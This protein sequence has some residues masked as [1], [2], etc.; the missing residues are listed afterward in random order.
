LLQLGLVLLIGVLLS[1]LASRLRVPDILLFVLVGFGLAQFPFE[2]NPVIGFTPY[3][4][5]TVSLFA[6]ALIVFEGSANFR[7]GE[8]DH[9]SAATLKLILWSIVLHMS[10][11]TAAAVMLGFPVG[12]AAVFAGILLGT[13]AP[14]VIPLLGK[15][16][17]EMF[18]LLKLESLLNTPVNV[19][20]PFLLLDLV[21]ATGGHD[22]FTVA[23]AQL[24]PFLLKLFVGIG[25]GVLAGIILFKVFKRVYEKVH[26]P[27]SLLISA[28]VSFSIAEKLGGSGVLAVTAQGMLFGNMYLAG[29]LRGRLMEVQ[30]VFSRSLYILL[31]MLFGSIL[32]IDYSWG[33]LLKG[34]VLTLAYLVIRWLVVLFALGR[35][36]TG[37]ARLFMTL[38]SPNGA[39]AIAVAAYVGSL[40]LPAA[41]EIAALT[42]LVV[43]LQIIIASAAVRLLGGMAEERPIRSGV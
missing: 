6:L 24:Q 33:F 40:A 13:S 8:V 9:L 1:L 18:S 39:S 43:L 21:T 35:H 36:I 22:V 17:G 2:H 28:L 26:S 30:S 3:F 12:M 37:R 23:A 16:R 38:L 27:L 32:A 19:V 34:V 42:G 5:V 11:F 4:I 15:V 25:V 14:V 7:L 20:V 41:R 29:H 10:L 31:F